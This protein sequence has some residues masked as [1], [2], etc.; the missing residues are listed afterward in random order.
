MPI[1]KCP[2]C[3]KDISDK[4][5]QCPNCGCPA[6]QWSGAPEEEAVVCPKCGSH[7]ITAGQ[8][9]WTVTTGLLGSSATYITCL[10]CGFKWSAAETEK[11]NRQFQA[12]RE[13]ADRL[14]RMT[15]EERMQ[16]ENQNF[17]K[18]FVIGFIIFIV[19]VIAFACDSSL[20]K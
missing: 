5:P 4:A 6:S 7:Q 12:E 1:I 13:K 2:E 18:F 19:L 8:R 3:Q 9:G 10:K 14:R 16:Y 11:Y 15:P 20:I 17:T